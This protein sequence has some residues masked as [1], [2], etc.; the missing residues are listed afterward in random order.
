MQSI[1]TDTEENICFDCAFRF[2]GETLTETLIFSFEL[3]FH[4]LPTVLIKE[5]GVFFWLVN[6][7]CATRTWKCPF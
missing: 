3:F 6:L 7:F 4:R 2:V 5:D 1:L